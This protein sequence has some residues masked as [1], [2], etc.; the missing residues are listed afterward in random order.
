MN[1]LQRAGAGIVGVLCALALGGCGSS[2]VS[3]TE[4]GRSSA[5]ETPVAVPVAQMSSGRPRNALVLLSGGG[6]PLSNHY[7]Q[8]LQARALAAFFARNYPNEPTWVF[9]GYGNRSRDTAELAD[10]HHLVVRDGLEIDTWEPGVLPGNRPAT[11]AS[12]LKALREEILPTVRDGG[13]L[14][15]FIGDHGELTKGDDGE[16]AVTMWQLKRVSRRRGTWST[17]EKELLPVSE[18]RQVLAEGL[19]RGRVVFCMTQCHSGG[20]HYLGIPREVTPPR[21][22]FAAVPEWLRTRRPATPLRIAGFTATDEE[23]VAAGCVSDPDPERWA[24]YERF[25]PE[26]VIGVD[27]MTDRMRSEPRFSLAAAHEAATLVDYTIDKPRATSEQY[28]ERWAQLIE[29]RLTNELL[30]AE[31]TRRAV[32]AYH[33]A[34]E[35]GAIGAAEGELRAK[36]EQFGRYT[37]RLIEQ[38][39]ATR[40]LLLRGTRKQLE[41]PNRGGGGGRGGPRG[42]NRRGA[43]TEGRRAWADT[44][45]P[46]WEAAI[47][48][49]NGRV[50]DGAVLEFERDLLKEEEGNRN[51]LLPRGVDEDTLLNEVYWGS[52]Y[53]EPQKFDRAKAEAITR[54][55]AERQGRIV[56]WGKA[57]SDPNLRAAAEKIE[58]AIAARAGPATEPAAPTT[59]VSRRT[60]AERVLF[61]RRVLA[62]WEFLV[63]ME[64]QPEL[65]RLHE[66]IAIERTPLPAPVPAAAGV[67]LDR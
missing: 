28:L 40:D 32:A 58:A 57:S 44:L 11:R 43:M 67:A 55:A 56:S 37:A 3:R 42:G 22:W 65:A 41:E 45:R 29:S 8:Y 48:A 6:T 39:G 27:L 15:L 59:T 31:K 47:N 33:R 66:L 54:W 17:D 19:G 53:A 46:A 12:F 34:V 30:L 51:F 36:Q 25:A 4:P 21:A 62:A 20:F 61:Y 14:Y 52:T 23:S 10:A 63:A 16:S 7:S 50:L 60:A 38:N 18:L 1:L 24:G 26:A 9:F 64:A 49:P 35:T 13:T 5:T 2:P